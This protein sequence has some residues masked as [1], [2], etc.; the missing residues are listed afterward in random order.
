MAPGNRPPPAAPQLP[1]RRSKH[2][3]QWVPQVQIKP[4]H[5]D[6]I[7]VP[8]SR[9]APLQVE[10]RREEEYRFAARR[11]QRFV[12]RWSPRGA[13]VRSQAWRLEYR[14][15]A[16]AARTRKTGRP[17]SGCP[18]FRPRTIRHS[19]DSRRSAVL[20]KVSPSQKRCTSAAAQGLVTPT[21]IVLPARRGTTAFQP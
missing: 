19:P 4:L 18:S 11:P 8:K 14:K 20:T 13:R 21:T 7:S 1:G 3:R 17:K 10:A 12:K 9:L 2:S 15:I 6:V 16:V 5:G